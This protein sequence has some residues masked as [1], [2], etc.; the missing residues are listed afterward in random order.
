MTPGLL[1]RRLCIE[2]FST[3]IFRCSAPCS[4]LSRGVK[5]DGFMQ[6]LTTHVWCK[7][8]LSSRNGPLNKRFAT[9]CDFQLFRSNQKLPYLLPSFPFFQNQHAPWSR[10]CFFPNKSIV[11]MNVP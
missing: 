1:R 11:F 9:I 5:C 3:R 4:P 6:Y 2:G 7:C 8:L 10:T